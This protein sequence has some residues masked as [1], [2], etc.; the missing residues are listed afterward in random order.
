MSKD[1]GYV[2]VPYIIQ[3]TD[4]I[5]DSKI[6]PKKKKG[7]YTDVA[8]KTRQERRVEKIDKII[9]ETGRNL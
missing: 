7:R 9:N 1:P 8:I 6:N 5:I 2:F 4:Q 3:E